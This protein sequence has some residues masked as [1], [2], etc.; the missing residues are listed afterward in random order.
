MIFLTVLVVDY[1]CP[2][3]FSWLA[4]LVGAV[5]DWRRAKNRKVRLLYSL[6]YLY[7]ALGLLPLPR[8]VSPPE[9][10]I[11]KSSRELRYGDKKIRIGLGNHPDGQKLEEGDGKT[12]EG[13]YQVCSKEEGTHFGL[14]IGLDY[15]SRQDAWAGRLHNQIS[16]L[17]LTRW[18]WF[19][20]S[21]PPQTTRLGG[22]VGIHG[23]G[24]R[25][26]WTLGC[27]ALD[28]TDIKELFQLLPVG[29]WVEI[30]P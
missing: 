2:F 17:E 22:Q 15:P 13:S 11:Y 5:L 7:L 19:W 21:E 6:L 14:W 24:S 16:W 25:R 10:I 20:R 27:V 3:P 26:N 8:H 30:R 28:D 9:V 29:A 12:P 4:L 1:V 18:N 23:G